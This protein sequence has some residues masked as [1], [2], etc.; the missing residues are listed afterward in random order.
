M[1]LILIHGHL[2]VDPLVMRNEDTLRLILIEDLIIEDEEGDLIRL[3]LKEHKG[4][5]QLNQIAAACRIL[6]LLRGAAI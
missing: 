6:R 4:I 2:H 1:T 3:W 5:S